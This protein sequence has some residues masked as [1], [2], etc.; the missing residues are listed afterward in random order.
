MNTSLL[1]DLVRRKRTCIEQLRD[2]AEKQMALIEQDQITALLDLLAHKQRVL[3]R[4]QQ[5]EVAMR[6][7]HARTPEADEWASAAERR[8]CADDL[9]ACK[10][11]L[12]EL[13][14]REK[15]SEG[16]LTRRRDAAQAALQGTH[17]AIQARNAYNTRPQTKLA[18][19]DLSSGSPGKTS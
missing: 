15:E 17:L 3:V 5:V 4:L 2:L 12:A 9:E 8:Q 7:F 18:Q 16:A 1:A 11:L 10:R 13:V 6:P 19:I 14:A